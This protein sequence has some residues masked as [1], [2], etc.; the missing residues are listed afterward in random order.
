MR[1]FT[2]GLD[3]AKSVFQV[4]GFDDVG[5]VVTRKR[6][7]RAKMRSL[8][9]GCRDAS[10]VSRLVRR[11]TIGLRELQALGYAVKLMPPSY[12]KAYL[13]S[14]KNDGSD[15]RRGERS[16]VIC[17]MCDLP[18]AR[19]HPILALTAE[20]P[21]KVTQRKCSTYG[22]TRCARKLTLGCAVSGGVDHPSLPSCFHCW[23]PGKAL[24]SNPLRHPLLAKRQALNDEPQS[25]HWKGTGAVKS[26]CGRSRWTGTKRSADQRRCPPGRRRQTPRANS[27]APRQRGHRTLTPTKGLAGSFL[28][29]GALSRSRTGEAVSISLVLLCRKLRSTSLEHQTPSRNS[30]KIVQT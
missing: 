23:R 24:P 13:K 28:A 21:Q 25:L 15:L 17:Q 9:Q 11:P 27:P 29:N 2:I 10:L 4:H 6:V 8:S 5:A 26:D 12:A 7:S 16:Y 1:L 14:S 18:N 20:F 19:K 30:A 3:V 22:G